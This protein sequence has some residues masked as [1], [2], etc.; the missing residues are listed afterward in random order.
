MGTRV[1]AIRGNKGV[2]NTPLR[3]S[4]MMYR[5][6]YNSPIG[7]IEIGA[8]DDGVVALSFLEA[9]TSLPATPNHW[10]RRAGDD[11]AQYFNGTLQ[12][13]TIP[14][15]PA[16]TAFQTAVWR[17]L[18]AIPHGV[19]FSYAEIAKRIGAPRA[20]R[21]VGLACGANP[22]PVMIP[23]HRVLSKTRRLTGFSG[24]LF[25]KAFL[26]EHEGIPYRR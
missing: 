13:F 7:Q 1:Y 16:G 10:T 18:A 11:L 22:I 25:R 6:Y 14:T 2:C 17:A 15:F 24:G 26:L 9:P 8:T 4:Y 21:A 12:H 5:D 23:C 19:S 3:D 20:C